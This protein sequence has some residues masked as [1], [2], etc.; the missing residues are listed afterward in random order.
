MVGTIARRI[1]IHRATTVGPKSP[2][3]QVILKNTSMMKDVPSSL[4]GS[5]INRSQSLLTT[6]TRIPALAPSRG[7]RARLEA[8]LSDVWSREVLPF[9]GM[10]NRSRS[11]HIV[12]ASASSMIRKLSVASIASSF[13][14]RS[15]SLAS[16]NKATTDDDKTEMG[17][18]VRHVPKLTRE[19]GWT[20]GSPLLRGQEDR[21][22]PII[23]DDAERKTSSGTSTGGSAFKK[24]D[25]AGTVAGTVRRLDALKRGSAPTGEEGRAVES[26]ALRTSSPNS[27]RLIRHTSSSKTSPCP[28]DKE[29]FY[30]PPG[31]KPPL[32][33]KPP[34]SKRSSR[35]A[36]VGA[37]NRDVMVQGLRSFFR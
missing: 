27:L 29:N 25:V 33:S 5:P 4:S 1:S 8:L 36:R 34:L 24:A 28:S 13:T 9:P 15:A 30:Q 10:T 23:R 19:E 37:L 3:C 7:E 2:L 12:R 35:W 18:G 26:T 14:K 17:D 16:T 31:A 6:N 22:L 32:L 20:S 21:R 11:E